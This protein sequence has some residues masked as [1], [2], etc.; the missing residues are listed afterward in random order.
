MEGMM[1]FT[2]PSWH[3]YFMVIAKIC[4]SRSTCLSRPTGAVIV[5]DKHILATGYNGAMPGTS[6]CTDEGECFRRRLHIP[7]IDKY[8]FCRATHAEAN[9]LA[10]AARYGISVE[11]AVLYTTLAPCYVCLK[12]LATARIHQIYYEH[13]YE[14]RNA[15]RDSFWQQAVRDAGIEM[16]KLQV[17]APALEKIKEHLEY[18]TSVRR[19][20]A[21][22]F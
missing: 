16:T 2:R 6:H 17:S 14:S 15:E 3:E 13:H 4:S 19:L 10:Q 1:N 7:D 9:A 21:T 11:G 8:N 12:L 18:P 20:A 22:E 5:L